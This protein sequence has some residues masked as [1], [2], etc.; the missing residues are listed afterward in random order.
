MVLI[1]LSDRPL[2]FKLNHLQARPIV[3]GVLDED[4]KSPPLLVIKDLCAA[5]ETTGLRTAYVLSSLVNTSLATS[6]LLYQL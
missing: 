3:P 6:E 4:E 5:G 1:T 2:V